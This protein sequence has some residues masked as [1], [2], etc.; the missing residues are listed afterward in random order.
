MRTALICHADA[1][2]DRDGLARWLSSFSTYTGTLVVREPASRAR[3]R[4]AREIRRVG[5]LRFVDVLAF[6]VAYRLRQAAEDR[7]WEAR[8][9]ARLRAAFRTAAAPELVVASPNSAE[10]EAFL[11]ERQ[12]DL[13]IARCKMLLAERIFS[14]PALGTFVLHPGICPDYRNAHGC[15]WAVA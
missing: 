3:R 15:F 7:Q 13:V 1:P 8:A 10:A 12:P 4:V 14:I 2:L 6:R 5:W 9:L 11:R